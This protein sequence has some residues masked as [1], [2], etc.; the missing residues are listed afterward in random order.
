MVIAI[1]SRL[2]TVAEEITEQFPAARHF[3]TGSRHFEC[4]MQA[5]HM[6]MSLVRVGNAGP[7]ARTWTRSG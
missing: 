4:S 6:D 5:P 2:T 1:S 3:G 7:G